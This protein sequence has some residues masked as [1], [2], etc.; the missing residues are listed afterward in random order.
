MATKYPLYRRL[1]ALGF[2]CCLSFLL[3]L[4]VCL[5]IL[6]TGHASPFTSLSRLLLLAVTLTFFLAL[7]HHPAPGGQRVYAVFN[8]LFT[9]AGLI[10]CIQTLW[11]KVP[12]EDLEQ[13]V[14]TLCE[15]PFEMLMAQQQNIIDKLMLLVSLSPQCAT[16]TLGPFNTGYPEQA[17]ALFILLFLLTW[18]IIT[19]RPKP[20]G[21]FQ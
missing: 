3:Y 5:Q 7:L 8:L 4:F 20:T 12:Q 10:L 13:A 6:S 17:L 1:N 9:S 15:M 2:I 14:Q 18:K 16:E 21:M 19:H 11:K